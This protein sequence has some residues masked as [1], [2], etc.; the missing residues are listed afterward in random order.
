MISVDGIVSTIAGRYGEKGLVD[1]E[2]DNARFR[3]ILGVLVDAHD[4]IYVSDLGKDAAGVLSTAVRKLTKSGSSYVTTTIV[5]INSGIHA[6]VLSSFTV[7]GDLLITEY[8][9]GPAAHHGKVHVVKV[10]CSLPPHL[11]GMYHK[12]PHPSDIRLEAIYK[13]KG[14]LFENA[15]LNKADITFTVGGRSIAAHRGNLMAG[16]DYFR[17]M[18]KSNL[19]EG[20]SSTTEVQETTYEALRTVLKYIYT[21]DHRDVLTVDNVLSVYELS[22]KYLLPDLQDH[23]IWYMQSSSN[24]EATVQWYI[25]INAAAGYERVH[26]MLE[27]KLVKNFALLVERHPDLIRVLGRNDLS[28]DIVIAA[29]KE[30]GTR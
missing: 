22:G 27:G 8:E 12:E 17:Q 30:K 20:E 28:T 24:L 18:F 26:C 29:W 23:C 21:Q 19:K 25:D 7:D 6:G 9:C 4:N 15:A 10:G 13:M 3:S 1:G 2:G 11:Q 14:D 5:P 16:S